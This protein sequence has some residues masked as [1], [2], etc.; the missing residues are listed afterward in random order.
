MCR[1]HWLLCSPALL[2]ELAEFHP[3]F[4]F[5]ISYP[6]I[7]FCTS[8]LRGL[9]RLS[10]LPIIYVVNLA[11]HTF[12]RLLCDKKMDRMH[13]VLVQTPLL[14]C[15]GLLLLFKMA[16]KHTN[17]LEEEL[18]PMLQQFTE[19]RCKQQPQSSTSIKAMDRWRMPKQSLARKFILSV[20][21]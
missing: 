2:P 1:Y 19:R 13:D 7:W 15:S 9:F 17:S 3:S 8:N 16:I 5:C 4:F 10:C 18:W 12:L 6:T 20:V 14:A 21:N 11:L